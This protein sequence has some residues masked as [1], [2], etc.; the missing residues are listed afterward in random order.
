MA[1]TVVCGRCGLEMEIARTARNK[2]DVTGD[3]TSLIV[4]CAHRKDN[5]ISATDQDCPDLQAA[6]LAAAQAGLV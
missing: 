5:I 4:R 2:I 1:T 3:L 6:I